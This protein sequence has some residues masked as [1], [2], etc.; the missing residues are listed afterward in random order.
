MSAELL[1]KFV[2]RNKKDTAYIMQYLAC[3]WMAALLFYTTPA[4]AANFG[5]PDAVENTIE[6][7]ASTKPAAVEERLLDNWFDWK[8][9]IQKDHGISLGIDYTPVYL[10]SSENGASGDNSASSGM[11]RF[12]GSWDLVGRGTKDTGALIWK[13]EH[14]H[15]YSDISPQSFGFD[16]G[17]IGLIEPPFSDEGG[18][19]TNLFWRQRLNDG[20]AT[21]TAG[22]LD[23]TDYLNLYSLTSPWT[24]FMN[25]A[26]STG[27]QTMF[28]PNDATTGIAGATMLG[29]NYYVI[30]GI[31]NAYTD[32]TRPFDTFDDFFSEREHFTSLELGWAPS[33]GQIFFESTHLTYWHVDASV[34]AGTPGGWGLAFNYTKSLKNN[35][36]K[37]FLR[38]GYAD[39][40]GTLLQKSLNIGFGYNTFDGRDELGVGAQWGQPNENSFGPNLK[41][42]YVFEVFY[43]FQLAQQLAITPDIQYLIDPALNPNHDSLWVLGLRA[44]LAL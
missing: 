4:F 16:Q 22:L 21:I 33:Q 15:K 17:Y 9:G 37:P 23:A 42:Q 38:G 40:G 18:R 12:F 13:V 28:I 25:F 32:P 11:V 1:D 2:G 39:D 35:T 10:R 6:A 44:R 14:R 34:P 24:G 31:V 19:W 26:F 30:A 3:A 29:D 7:D 43:R 5:G 36:F 41:D 8:A 20:T 27:S